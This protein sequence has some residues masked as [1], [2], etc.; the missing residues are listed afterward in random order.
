MTVVGCTSPPSAEARVTRLRTRNPTLRLRVAAASGSPALRQVRVLLPN[1]L[2]AK[3]KRARR[4]G[5]RA[6]ADGTKLPRR[7]IGLT[8]D[9]ELL[10]T[11]PE[12]TRTLR[13]TLSRGALRV[14]RKLARKR[15]PKRLILRVITRDADGARPPVTLKVRPRRR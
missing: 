3:P 12:A 13:A 15:N 2:A 10:I 8:R 9:G 1:A 4:G 11:L 7:S 5:L 6:R 14:S